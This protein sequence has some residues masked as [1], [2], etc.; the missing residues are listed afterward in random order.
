MQLL[1]I[2][3]SRGLVFIELTNIRTYKSAPRDQ[4]LGEHTLLLR[5]GPELICYVPWILLVE[6]Q[7]LRA[8]LQLAITV[9]SAMRPMKQER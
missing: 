2:S 8:D 1:D 5:I 4:I 7:Y 9:I 3:T 6:L